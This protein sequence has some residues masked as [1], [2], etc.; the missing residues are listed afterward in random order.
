MEIS[1]ELLSEVLGEKV[2][3]CGFVNKNILKVKFNKGH[4][5]NINIHELAHKCK[6]WVIKEGYIIHEMPYC[7]HLIQVENEIEKTFRYEKEDM[8]NKKPYLPKYTFKACEWI[9]NNKG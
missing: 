9:L 4:S 6:E 2:N 7:V 1:K 3:C 8:Q 5:Y